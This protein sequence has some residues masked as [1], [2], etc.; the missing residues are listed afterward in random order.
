M[1]KRR[2]DQGQLINVFSIALMCLHCIRPLLNSEEQGL[3]IPAISATYC[4]CVH[5][6][7][8]NKIT[9][10]IKMMNL[11]SLSTTGKRVCFPFQTSA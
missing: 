11:S 8:C 3:L 1:K 6:L 7:V 10:I 2:V 4:K 5:C 9:A